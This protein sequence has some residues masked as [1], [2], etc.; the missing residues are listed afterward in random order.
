MKASGRASTSHD[1]CGRGTIECTAD[2]FSADYDLKIPIE[3]TLDTSGLTVYIDNIYI[4]DNPIIEPGDISLLNCD[5]VGAS[6]HIVKKM[7]THSPFV[8]QNSY[9][10][11]TFDANGGTLTGQYEDGNPYSYAFGAASGRTSR[12]LTWTLTLEKVK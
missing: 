4:K 8:L 12:I 5:E 6:E 9:R 3:M 2:S 7:A 10:K 1:F 11:E